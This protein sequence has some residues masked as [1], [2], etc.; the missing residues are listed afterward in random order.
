[1][2]ESI[3]VVCTWLHLLVTVI[4]IGHMINS[5]ILFTPLACKYVK[6]T[7]YGNFIA[8]YRRRDQPVALSC[9]AV[10][11]LTGI[12]LTLLDEYYEGIGNVF[13]NTWSVVLFVKHILVLAMIG[14][15]VYIGSQI[16]PKLAKASQELT[17]QKAQKPAMVASIASLEKKRRVVNLALCGLGIAVLFL[18][19][20]GGTL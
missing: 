11:I 6:E 15:G 12:G 20:F 19:A 18:T 5:V 8:E 10:F 4:W 13:A 1:M 17:T 3:L 14:I 9:I 16:M 7:E 2:R